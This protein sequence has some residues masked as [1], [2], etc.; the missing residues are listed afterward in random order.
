[1]KSDLTNPVATAAFV[2][3]RPDG[4]RVPV[5]A[6]IGRPYM[7]ERGEGRCP[8]S[9]SGIDPQYPDICGEGTLQALCL[10]LRLVHTRLEHQLEKG[11]LL[12]AEGEQ[13]PLDKVNLAIALGIAHRFEAGST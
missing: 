13:E 8:A 9:L 4:T 2:M 7:V 11:N 1:V 12:F 3:V 5:T 10:A 6:I